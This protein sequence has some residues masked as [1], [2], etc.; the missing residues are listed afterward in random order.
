MELKLSLDLLEEQGDL[1]SSGLLSSCLY[2]CWL[3]VKRASSRLPCL[4]GMD[5]ICDGDLQIAHALDFERLISL[6]HLL[7]ISEDDAAIR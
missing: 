4:I 3:V 1:V 5:L 6:I 2:T 7:G